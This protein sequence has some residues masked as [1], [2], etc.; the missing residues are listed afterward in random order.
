MKIKHISNSIL[1]LLKKGD[2]DNNKPINIFT[3]ES[4]ILPQFE[5]Q[6][7]N[8]YNGSKFTLIRITSKM[9]GF[10]FGDF[11]LCKLMTGAIHSDIIK[12]KQNNKKPINR[13]KKK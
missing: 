13:D 3:R 8:I 12:N 11:V 7:V 10:R 5:N 1:R 9:I 4:V 2:L 6:L